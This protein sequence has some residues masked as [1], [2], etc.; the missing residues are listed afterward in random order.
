MRLF[1]SIYSNDL[2]N[3]TTV[4]PDHTATHGREYAAVLNDNPS[5]RAPRV[6]LKQVRRVR[7]PN[8]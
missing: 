1:P 8:H 2:A 5:R 6:K 7:I 3:L 4:P